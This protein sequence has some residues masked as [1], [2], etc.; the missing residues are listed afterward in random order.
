MSRRTEAK[1]VRL[2]WQALASVLSTHFGER[3]WFTYSSIQEAREAT[4]V[5]IDHKGLKQ[6]VKEWWDWN[7]TAGCVDD[8][9]LPL[10]K[11]GI[12]IP[13]DTA[14][15]ARKFANSLYDMWIIRVRDKEPGWQP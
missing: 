2:K 8:I 4:L 3:F 13:F 10:A 11:I 15:D 12:E 9:R 1:K 14:A 5:G 7:A 6:V